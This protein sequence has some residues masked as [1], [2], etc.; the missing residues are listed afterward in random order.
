MVVAFQRAVV[1]THNRQRTILVVI[2]QVS[3]VLDLYNGL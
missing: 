2:Q 3:L 1:G